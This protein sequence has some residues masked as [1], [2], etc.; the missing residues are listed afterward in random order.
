VTIILGGDSLNKTLFLKEPDARNLF[1]SKDFNFLRP[2]RCRVR[3][4]VCV[5]NLLA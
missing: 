1:F 4:G 5:I 3:Q 2:P